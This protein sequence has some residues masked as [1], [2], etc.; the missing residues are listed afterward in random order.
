MRT[1]SS[2]VRWHQVT[3]SPPF[4]SRETP[5]SHLK[6]GTGYTRVCSSWIPNTHSF[7]SCRGSLFQ[8]DPWVHATEASQDKKELAGQRARGGGHG[9][10]VSQDVT[11]SESSPGEDAQGDCEVGVGA[12]GGRCACSDQRKQATGLERRS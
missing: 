5:G 3:Q 2:A 8:V 11:C 1:H 7:A 6:A 4:L 9:K 12:A 10:A